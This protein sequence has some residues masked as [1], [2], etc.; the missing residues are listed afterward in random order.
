MVLGHSLKD[1]NRGKMTTPSTSSLQLMKRVQGKEETPIPRFPS[2]YGFSVGRRT[3]WWVGEVSVGLVG[4]NMFHVI[5]LTLFLYRG[6]E[7]RDS[8]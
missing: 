5:S 3:G 1:N 8:P 6:T 4:G 7:G 2:P